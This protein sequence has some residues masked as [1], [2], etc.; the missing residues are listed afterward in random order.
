VVS[1]SIDNTLKVWELARG[2]ALAT[3]EGHTASVTACAVTPDNR[4]VVSASTDHTLKVWDLAT[5]TCRSTHR[6]DAA[7]LAVAVTATAVVAG[8]A[9]GVVW[10]LNMSPSMASPVQ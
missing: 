6:G 4:H 10:F 9:A 7:Y 1:A 2:R 8:D 5:H 3:L